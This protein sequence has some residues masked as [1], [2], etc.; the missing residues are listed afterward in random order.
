MPR[1]L[2]SSS[3]LAALGSQLVAADAVPTS[4]QVQ[5]FESK[6]RPLLANNCYECHGAKKQNNGLRLDSRE[7][8]LAGGDQGPAIVPGKPDESLIVRAVRHDGPKM[9]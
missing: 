5:F 3:F 6:I 4:E 9:P 8:I 7:A 2:I 1:F